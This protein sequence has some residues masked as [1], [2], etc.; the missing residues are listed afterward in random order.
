M[1]KEIIAIGTVVLSLLSMSFDGEAAVSKEIKKKA[2]AANFSNDWEN[3]IYYC[4]SNDKPSLQNNVARMIYGYETF[5]WNED[6]VWTQGYTGKTQA[7]LTN[8]KGTY[9]AE[10]AGAWKYSKEEVHHKDN[11]I[12]VTYRIWMEKE[13]GKY[14]YEINNTHNK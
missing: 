2:T 7:S 13:D 10:A 4:K 14:P 5:A 1:R 6:Y 3:T 11:S 12:D 8:S 9:G